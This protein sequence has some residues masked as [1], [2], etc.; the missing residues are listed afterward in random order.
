MS[1]KGGSDCRSADS[2][3]GTSKWNSSKDFARRGRPNSNRGVSKEAA[4]DSR[5][6]KRKGHRTKMQQPSRT[7]RRKKKG[8]ERREK[9]FLRQGKERPRA[10]TE[11]TKALGTLAAQAFIAHAGREKRRFRTGVHDREG[12][13]Q[14]G[15]KRGEGVQR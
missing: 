3:K 1:V 13:M 2:I 4:H 5:N 7:L 11:T 6:C 12:A 9:Q 14:K 8:Y 10:S 15:V